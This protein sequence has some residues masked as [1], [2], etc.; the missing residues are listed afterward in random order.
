MRIQILVV[1][2]CLLGTIDARS[3]KKSSKDQLETK[4]KHKKVPSAIVAIEIV[5]PNEN[6]TSSRNKKRTI[7]SS[8]GYGYQQPKFEVYKYSQHDIPAWKGSNNLFSG[9]YT[10]QKSISYTLPTQKYTEVNNAPSKMYLP[11]TRLYSTLDQNGHIGQLSQNVPV[12]TQ[13]GHNPQ[14]PVIIL[15]VL[16]NQLND[17]HGS[18]HANLPTSHPFAA[19]I[20][21]LDIQSLLSNYL[22]QGQ[23]AYQQQQYEQPQQQVYQQEQPQAEPGYQYESPK[24]QLLTH[25]NYPSSAHTRV[26]FK[27]QHG[28]IRESQKDDTLTKTINVHVPPGIQEVKVESSEVPYTPQAQY[29]QPQPQ[30]EQPQAQYEQPQAQ[31]DQQQYY[32]YQQGAQAAQQQYEQPQALYQQPQQQY[33]DA[34]HY[35]GQPIVVPDQQQYQEV[36]QPL[37]A[38][39]QPVQQYESQPQHQVQPQQTYGQPAQQY[40]AQQFYYQKYQQGGYEQTEAPVTYV[41]PRNLHKR[42]L[43]SRKRVVVKKNYESD[44]ILQ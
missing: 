8:L 22:Q 31:Y 9:S 21:S 27:N 2:I 35:S 29:E 44:K 14:V 41:T 19:N 3:K 13:G 26:I 11:G 4:S 24:S 1:V 40:E 39:G 15:R 36:A 18:L 23:Q 17:P 38:Y 20:N 25:E 7:E 28:G 16:P 43:R 37:E 30:Y 6:K 5:D 33:Q 10:V 12:D 32:Y 34:Q 42:R